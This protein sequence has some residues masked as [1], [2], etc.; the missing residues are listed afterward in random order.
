MVR[1]F[2]Q[3]RPNLKIWTPVALLGWLP[4]L[5]QAAT[6]SGTMFLDD[7]KNGIFDAGERKGVNLTI[8]LFTPEGRQLTTLSDANGNFWLTSLSAGSSQ[9]WVD[10]PV[11]WQQTAPVKAAGGMW[12]PYPVNV[13]GGDQTVTV[14]FGLLPPTTETTGFDLNPDKSITISNS[15]YSMRVAPKST[16]TGDSPMVVTELQKDSN[17]KG[18]NGAA[19]IAVTPSNT[20]KSGWRDNSDTLTITTGKELTGTGKASTLD[21]TPTRDG[22]YAIVD[23]DSPTTQT[24]LNADSSYDIADEILFP[25][26]K[27]KVRPDGTQLVTH[28]DFPGLMA[29]IGKD[30]S[31]RVTDEAFLG[32]AAVV[33]HD[34]SYTVTD[35]KYPDLLAT[36]YSD[37]SY[38]VTDTKNQITVTIDKDGNYT[39]IDDKDGMCY[40]NPP[41]PPNTRGFG[42]WL[43]KTFIDPIK[44]FINK[45]AGF[46]SKVAGFVAGVAKFVGKVAEIIGK[47]AS[48]VAKVATFL[49]PFIPFACPFLCTVA[50][51]ATI[52]EAKSKIVADYAKKVADIAQKVQQGANQVVLWTK[53]RPVHTARSRDTVRSPATS[54]NC[55]KLPLVALQN[56]VAELLPNHSKVKVK[57]DTLVEFGNAGFNVYRAQK[58]AAG[59]YIDITQVNESLIP[60]QDNGLGKH[61]YVHT[62]DTIVPGKT[63]YYGIESIDTEGNVTTYEDLIVAARGTTLAD[64]GNFT[65]TPVQNSILL[66]WETFSEL[67]SVGFNLWRATA[68]DAS[69]C[70]G[71]NVEDY[72]EVTKLTGR[73]I[74]ATGGLFQGASYAYQDRTVKSQTTYCYGLEEIDRQGV[75]MVYWD[76]IIPA[77]AR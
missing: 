4:L 46:I 38:K 18:E 9:V 34:G 23:R 66:N 33:H 67:D 41:N 77:M 40:V 17:Y 60:S 65:A 47:V 30:G 36:A 10:L 49:A 75:S 1:W 24:K 72:S 3:L 15:D 68:P 69:M 58:D 59:N 64:L 5:V 48:V 29:M 61:S 28:R 14:N 8:Y 73:L 71:K 42:D 22:G 37:G 6:L 39:L 70:K 21:F 2:K 55:M 53:S 43:K 50:A 54:Q 45:V 74:P 57:W 19:E 31:Q 62:D 7:N 27:A 63:Y 35:V 13:P 76:S 56:V 26:A 51:F 16:N 32:M 11:G 44:G 20:V 52:V 12:T 25:G